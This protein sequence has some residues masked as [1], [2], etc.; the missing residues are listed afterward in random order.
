MMD[1]WILWKTVQKVFLR[2]NIVSAEGLK[3]FDEFRRC[4]ME[5]RQAQTREV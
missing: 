5:E 3:D 1:V 2:E 4:Q